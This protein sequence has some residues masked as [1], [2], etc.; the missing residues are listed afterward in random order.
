[1]ASINT[2]VR[3]ESIAQKSEPWLQSV[4]RSLGRKPKCQCK[5]HQQ[6]LLQKQHEQRQKLREQ[7]EQEGGA[8]YYGPT[9]K[10][11]IPDPPPTNHNVRALRRVYGTNIH[12]FKGHENGLIQSF[13]YFSCSW[14]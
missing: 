14:K 1:M 9:P 13:L 3:G 7:L 5:H 2:P 12:T 4:K 11:S 10:T 6:K 8:Q